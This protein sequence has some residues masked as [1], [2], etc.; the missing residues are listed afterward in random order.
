MAEVPG[1]NRVERAGGV[2]ERGVNLPADVP[3]ALRDVFVRA[4][5]GHQAAVRL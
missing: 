5:Y 3:S 1:G 4:I 2:D